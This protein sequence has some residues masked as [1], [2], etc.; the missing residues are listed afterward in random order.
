MTIK[1]LYDKAKQNGCEDYEIW[2]SFWDEYCPA[3]EYDENVIS[4]DEKRIYL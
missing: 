4:N 3:D 2:I 1:E